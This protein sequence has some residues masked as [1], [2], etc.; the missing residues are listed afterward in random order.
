MRNISK[1]FASN[2]YQICYRNRIKSKFS[3]VMGYIS[4]GQGQQK[5]KKKKK[6]KKEIAKI[7]N[8]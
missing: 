6:K 1:Y 5:K 4:Y 7:K 3:E 8:D 2:R